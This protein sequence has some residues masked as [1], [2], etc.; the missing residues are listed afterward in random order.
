M[1][2]HTLGRCLLALAV[3]LSGTAIAVACPFC[4]PTKTT[5]RDE[6]A[7]SD[8]VVIAEP[9]MSSF[10]R[11]EV[12][13]G[14]LLSDEE[15]PEPTF[16]I[17]QWLKGQER[18]QAGEE[19]QIPYLGVP[20]EGQ[21]FLI[22]G[23]DR[24]WLDEVRLNGPKEEEP[25]RTRPL[26]VDD[27]A[28]GVPNALTDASVEYLQKLQTL[29]KDP[30]A[31]LEFFQKYFEHEDSLLAA[32]AYNEFAIANY[33]AIKAVG[34]KLDRDQLIAWIQDKK[35]S[36]SRRRQYLSLLSLCGTEKEIPMLEEMMASA[37]DN[38]L[39]RN[40]LDAVIGCYLSL[41]GKEGLPV[42]EEMFLRNKEAEFG[43]IHN[44]LMA[45]RTH[46]EVLGVLNREDIAKTL[47]AVLERPDIADL[48]VPD[49]A[50]LE[51]WSVTDKLVAMFK[52]SD[53][54]TGFIRVPIFRFLMECPLP[55]AEAKLEELAEL[56]PANFRKARLGIG[57]GRR[58]GVETDADGEA[59]EKTEG[60]SMKPDAAS[61][62]PEGSTET[63]QPVPPSNDPIL[64]Q[65]IL[66]GGLVAQLIGPRRSTVGERTVY[67]IRIT[68][69]SQTVYDL[70]GMIWTIDAGLQPLE[71]SDGFRFG[72]ETDELLVYPAAKFDA[73]QT[74]QFRVAVMPQ[75]D[76][77]ASRIQ[78]GLFD[79]PEQLGRIEALVAI[80]PA[81]PIEIEIE[82]STAHMRR[83][84]PPW[85]GQVTLAAARPGD[86]SSEAESTG[87]VIVAGD[88]A[89]VDVASN[90]TPPSEPIATSPEAEGGYD[91]WENV[92]RAMNWKL[93]AMVAGVVALLALRIYWRR[94][95]V[96][97]E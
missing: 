6:I 40:S 82:D 84:S 35:V 72:G 94:R 2:R 48:V 4:D 83:R 33:E 62:A 76:A 53:E 18:Y 89:P 58:T 25:L 50:R 66:R 73:G 26:G 80:D 10:K 96:V 74:R 60:E 5:I 56:D 23:M 59:K 24:Q 91:L 86:V 81:P 22:M 12:K 1:N 42:I 55:E 29:P 69:S 95:P 20:T 9:V 28:W 43:L 85:Q 97:S 46:A 77:A 68:N 3:L 41:R 71:A 27:I 38:L 34:P 54:K 31:Q 8:L 57:F 78:V 93:A 87:P 45:L 17:V 14:Q 13:V 90:K 92:D 21:Q 15:F 67:N 11:P 19:I 79:G 7:A 39:A 30:V 88:A 37:D 51:D 52:A 36:A 32:E 64:G 63:A 47:R 44:A 16:K 75:I 61:T 49:L 70:V 65:A